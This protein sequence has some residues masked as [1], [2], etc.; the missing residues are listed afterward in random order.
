[1]PTLLPGQQHSIERELAQVEG[2]LH[3]LV[4]AIATGRATE[5]VFAELEREEGKK[6]VLAA[7]LA[8]LTTLNYFANG[9]QTI[10]QTRQ[11][12][13]KIIDGRILCTPFDDERG[14]GY[15]LEAT[16]TYAGLLGDLGVINNGGGGQGSR[17]PDPYVANVVLSQ[18]S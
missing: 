2:R 12:L 11:L 9:D 4:D 5:S 13:G 17:T 10:P 6:K 8:N 3:R 18:L 1:M 7:Q 14:R 16:G 15:T